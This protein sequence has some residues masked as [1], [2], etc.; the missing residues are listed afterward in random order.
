MLEHFCSL[1]VH[2]VQMGPGLILPR[3]QNPDLCSAVTKLFRRYVHKQNIPN[4]TQ[5][6]PFSWP[7]AILRTTQHK[8]WPES[9]QAPACPLDNC[10]SAAV[11]LFL[12][13]Y[14]TAPLVW[15][16][17]QH[18]LCRNFWHFSASSTSYNLLGFWGSDKTFT[19]CGQAA[20][21][22]FVSKLKH[23]LVIL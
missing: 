11:G 9:S 12:Y 14:H 4:P 2:I 20:V 7:P 6:H 8:D 10:P 1:F 16:Q 3:M 5:I 21:S 15:A 23:L 22:K 19:T 17:L 18:R 13:Y